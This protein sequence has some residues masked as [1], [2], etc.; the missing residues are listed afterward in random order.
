[1]KNVALIFTPDVAKSQKK[2]SLLYAMTAILLM[3]SPLSKQVGGDHYKNLVIQPFEFIERNGIGFAA[4][5]IIKY[6]CRYKTKN[7][8]EDLKKARH[9][10]DLLIDLEKGKNYASKNI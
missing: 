10:I 7:G 2:M 5:N 1:V 6:V 3:D 4:G 8:I 9:Y